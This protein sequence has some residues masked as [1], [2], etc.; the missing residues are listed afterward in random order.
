M[1]FLTSLRKHGHP[2]QKEQRGLVEQ[3]RK[4]SKPKCSSSE[5]PLVLLLPSCSCCSPKSHFSGPILSLCYQKAITTHFIN[6]NRRIP[7][8]AAQSWALAPGQADWLRTPPPQSQPCSVLSL[9]GANTLLLSPRQSCFP[10]S[11]ASTAVSCFFHVCNV[12]RGKHTSTE[13]W[14]NPRSDREG[15]KMAVRQSSSYSIWLQQIQLPGKCDLR[16]GYCFVFCL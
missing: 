11:R 1:A 10:H 15:F 7:C 14:G 9:P 8:H 3:R 4:Q 16:S 12:T 5:Q 6:A 13:R 2:A